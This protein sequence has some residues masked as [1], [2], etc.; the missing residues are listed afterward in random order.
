MQVLLVANNFPPIRGGSAAVYDSLARHSGGRVTVLAPRINYADGLPIIGWREH[1]R[2]APYPIMRLDL[3]RTIIGRP[4]HH[5]ARLLLGMQD[6]LIRGR[7]ALA[8]LRVI[9]QDPPRAICIGELLASGWM[10]RLL[11][12]A[13]N[14]RIVVYVHG[15]EITTDDRYDKKSR[16]RSQ[17]LRAAD[18]IIVVSRFTERIVSEL[19]GPHMAGRI[20][21]LE[22]G[23]DTERFTP[24][25]KCAPLVELYG[26]GGRFVFVSV[27]RL[28]EKKGI[29][30]ALRAFASMMPMFPDI[31]YLIVGSGPYEVALQRLAG[32]LGVRHRVV[33]AGAVADSDLVE[34]YRLGD[35]FVMPNRQL[36]NGDTEGFGLVFLEANACGIPVIAGSDGGSRDAV[37]DDQNGLLV[38]G[39]SVPDIMRAMRR[40][41]E[42]AALR[43]R[44]R[45]TGFN[46][47]ARADWKDKAEAFIRICTGSEPR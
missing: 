33:F 41:R 22:N 3:L 2:R 43:E 4:R 24:A 34:H 7:V 26:L 45:R 15:E 21:L 38:D 29:D 37:Q 8:L 40:L 18:A 25:P 9:R 32:E 14:I 10:I 42:D 36:P 44:I 27:C 5:G 47:A 17:A 16:R 6:M 13:P 35:V 23:V 12:Y 11:R 1:D 46:T 31:S 20:K 28:L 30:N 39:H 19:L